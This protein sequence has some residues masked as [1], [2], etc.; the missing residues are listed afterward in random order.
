MI[1]GC[2]SKC[3]SVNQ[4]TF[5]A[6]KMSLENKFYA[7]KLNV[8]DLSVDQPETTC[9]QAALKFTYYYKIAA[10]ISV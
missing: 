4:Q 8:Q 6:V 5:P 3:Q 7:T 2:L 10:R 1:I 9:A